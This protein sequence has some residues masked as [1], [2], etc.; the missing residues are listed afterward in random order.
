VGTN[1]V[2]KQPERTVE[3][4]A[5]APLDS[6]TRPIATVVTLLWKK[7]LLSSQVPDLNA[8]LIPELLTSELCQSA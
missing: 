5:F 4:I 2:R 3:Y 7:W 8:R 6:G 1:R